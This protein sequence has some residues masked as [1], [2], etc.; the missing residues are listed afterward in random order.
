MQKKLLCGSAAAD[1]FFSL[2]FS[3]TSEVWVQRARL[4]LADKQQFLE[5][6]KLGFSLHSIPGSCFVCQS[7]LAAQRSRQVRHVTRRP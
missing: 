5:V 4:L 6:C 1:A 3:G 2:N 7:Q